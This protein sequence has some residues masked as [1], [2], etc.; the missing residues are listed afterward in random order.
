MRI[1]RRRWTKHEDDMIRE[2]A[3][4]NAHLG[5]TDMGSEYVSRLRVLAETLGRS[6]GAVRV[7]ASRIR[8]ISYEARAQRRIDE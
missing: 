6:Y 2:C 1:R 7:R 3:V 4:R 8:A 5:L